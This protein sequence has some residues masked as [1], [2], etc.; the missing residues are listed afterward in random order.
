MRKFKVWCKDKNEW[1]QDMCFLD[2]EGTVWHQ[3]MARLMALREENHEVVFSTGLKDKNS[4][5]IYEGD[6]LQVE[7][8]VSTRKG[9]VIFRKGQFAIKQDN[10]I[11]FLLSDR[12]WG[13]PER[14]EILGNKF[15][16]SH[17]LE[18]DTHD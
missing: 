17:L 8:Y 1:E 5:A 7:T 14:L 15:E 18:A 4:K 12:F 10:D 13:E 16:D 11:T 9:V 3:T 2:G 6:I